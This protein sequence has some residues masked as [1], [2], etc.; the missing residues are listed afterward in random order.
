[1]FT[2]TAGQDWFRGFGP[3]ALGSRLRRLSDRMMSDGRAIYEEH[4][5]AFEPR[6]FPVFRA[7]AEHGP[8][9]VRELAQGLGYTHA[10]IS[11][12][13]DGLEGAELIAT[14]PDPTDER[15]RVLT[16]SP[17]GRALHQELRP[18]WNRI[19]GAL[20]EIAQGGGGDLLAAL[21]AAERALHAEPLAARVRRAAG[22]EVRI[23]DFRAPLRNHF[24]RLNV[25]WIEAEFT[26]EPHD[27]EVLRHP[28]R[29]L[30]GGGA[31][32]FAQVGLEIGGTC[33]LR[34]DGDGV[35]ELTKMA[36]DPGHQGLGLGRR[37]LGAAIARARAWDA[38]Q[39]WL[40][41]NSKLKPAIHLY[42]AL[43]FRDAARTVPSAYAR[44]D[45]HMRLDLAAQPDGDAPRIRA[46]RKGD[47]AGV[48]AIARELVADGTTYALDPDASDAALLADWL[49]PAEGGERTRCLV[50][51]RDGRVVGMAV[52]RP[53][54][55]G[56]GG[57]VANGAFAVAANAGGKGVGRALGEHALG[58]AMALGY[59]AMQFNFVVST[60]ERAVRLWSDLGFGV[61]GRLPGAFRH[62]RLGR[63]D[64][65]VMFRELGAR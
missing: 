9:G 64:A 11:Q 3:L 2:S 59:E 63:V 35:F 45:V 20:L 42:H 31:I 17:A 32:L 16:L 34:R 50:A 39:I 57:H 52:V 51:E 65:L 13:A 6:W 40:D 18:L 15:R 12:V 46:M 54:R 33:A 58:A 22:R 10:A 7:L 49:P 4:G 1:M 8:A 19:D 60:N 27:D 47:R 23:I 53:N 24:R 61:V 30:D 14:Q 43:G 36:V 37:L 29:M 44:S 26:L 38:R 56:A 48:L 41:T 25:R 21:D 62:P 5:V 28:E 55:A